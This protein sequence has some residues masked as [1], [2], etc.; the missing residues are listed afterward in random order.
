MHVAWMASTITRDPPIWGI[1]LECGNTTITVAGT[2][3]FVARKA[4]QL[5]ATAL[6]RYNP[7]WMLVFTE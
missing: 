5:M 6:T 3:T 2:C 4:V 7:I 1:L